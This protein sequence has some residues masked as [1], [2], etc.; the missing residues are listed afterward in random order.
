MITAKQ[1]LDAKPIAAVWSVKPDDTIRDAVRLMI[2]KGIGAVLV[3]DGESVVGIL[4]ERDCA[5]QLV[6]TSRPA[7]D[8]RVREWMTSRVVYVRPEQTVDECLALSSDKR[9]RHLP[10]MEGGRLIGMLSQ[11][12]LVKATISHQKFLIQQLENY[13]TGGR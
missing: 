13:I 9:V 3:R 2:D 7:G 10:V 11:G 4:S 1:M 6:L 5:R 8:V 12:D